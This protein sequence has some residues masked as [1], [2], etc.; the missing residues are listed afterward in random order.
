MNSITI[1]FAAQLIGFRKIAERLVGG[2]I[3]ASFG[4]FGEVLV[5]IV[6]ITLL[7]LFARMLYKKNIF[8]RL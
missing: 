2:S 6:T 4:S 7:F 5:G 3:K 1:Y 8:L